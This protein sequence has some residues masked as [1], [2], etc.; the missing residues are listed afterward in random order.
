M[1]LPGCGG[2][3]AILLLARDGEGGRAVLLLAGRGGWRAVT[4]LARYSGRRAVTLLACGGGGRAA[5]LLGLRALQQL[6]GER[7]TIGMRQWWRWWGGVMLAVVVLLLLML[8]VTVVH[9]KAVL[10]TL[11]ESSPSPASGSSA[12]RGS[13]KSCWRAHSNTRQATGM[14]CSVMAAPVQLA[15]GKKPLL[16]TASDLEVERLVDLGH[17]QQLH[18]LLRWWR[19]WRRLGRAGGRRGA[20]K[21]PGSRRQYTTPVTSRCAPRRIVHVRKRFAYDSTGIHFRVPSMGF[22]S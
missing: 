6:R 18:G 15:G 8:V 12:S 16:D 22:T 9:S 3:R 21:V 2:W 17:L 10:R 19:R 14:G 5:V 11:G 13:L 4:L 20:E 7:D 1:L